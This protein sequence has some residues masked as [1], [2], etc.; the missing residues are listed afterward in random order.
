MR[1]YRRLADGRSKVCQEDEGENT[2]REFDTEL[3]T[4]ERGKALPRHDSELGAD[5]E[6]IDEKDCHGNERPEQAVAI[7]RTGNRVRRDTT[8]VVI[9]RC[10]N[11]SRAHDCHEKR[12]FLPTFFEELHGKGAIGSGDK[13][14]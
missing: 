9:R 3:F 1:E 10:G 5:V 7:L 6:R 11:E 14:P 12:N 8:R 4:N 13:K 2:E